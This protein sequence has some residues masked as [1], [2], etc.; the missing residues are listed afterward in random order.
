MPSPPLTEKWVPLWP[1]SNPQQGVPPPIAGTWLKAEAGGMVWKDPITDADGN[2][3]NIG[4]AGEPPF[5][6][7]W[8]NYGPAYPKAGFRRLPTGMIAFRGLLANTAWSAP[9]V[10]TVCFTFP[11]SYRPTG[12]LHLATFGADNIASIRVSTDGTVNISSQTPGWVS[13]DGVEFF[14]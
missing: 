14:Q 4:E 7:T 3:H 11:V 5:Q 8:L 2:W 9:G 13:L 6:S 12:Y 10:S 1:L